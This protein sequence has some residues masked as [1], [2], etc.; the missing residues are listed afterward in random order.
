M[1]MHEEYIKK[2]GYGVDPKN[3]VEIS[4]ADVF[5]VIEMIKDGKYPD[6]SCSDD[7]CIIHGAISRLVNA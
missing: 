7:M 5:A 1:T 6:G 3:P 2:S 4:V